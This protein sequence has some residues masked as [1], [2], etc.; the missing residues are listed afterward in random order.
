MYTA[1]WEEADPTILNYT[2]SMICR[3][4]YENVNKIYYNAKSDMK[5]II[6]Y[7]T[8]VFSF[9]LISANINLNRHQG[10]NSLYMYE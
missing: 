1:E 7:N 8:E 3:M 6:D 2:T 9:H 10:N 4:Q 5:N